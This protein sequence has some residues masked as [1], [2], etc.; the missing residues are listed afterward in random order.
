MEDWNRDANV[1]LDVER[2]QLVVQ[3]A[4]GLTQ[5]TARGCEELL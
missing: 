1:S 4:V 2:L 3:E 5:G